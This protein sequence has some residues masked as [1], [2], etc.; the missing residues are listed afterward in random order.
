MINLTD[1][2]KA[3]LRAAIDGKTLQRKW[4]CVDGAIFRDVDDLLGFFDHYAEWRI[5]QDPVEALALMLI[6]AMGLHQDYEDHKERARRV[7]CVL[8]EKCPAL[9]EVEL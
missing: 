1:H 6:A 8:A 4:R 3:L 5:K 7:I 2:Q 9:L